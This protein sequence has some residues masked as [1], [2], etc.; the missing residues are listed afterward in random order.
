MGI[1]DIFKRRN[2][3]NI[4]VEKVRVDSVRRYNFLEGFKPKYNFG[5]QG[6]LYENQVARTCIDTIATHVAKLEP[7]HKRD[8]KIVQGDIHRIINRQPNPLMNRYD[9]I[10]KVV[11]NLY[12]KNNA[13]IYIHIENGMLKSL[14]PISYNNY[15]MVEDEKGN[16]YLSFYYLNGKHYILPMENII[17]LRRFYNENDYM[18]E[19][20]DV[21]NEAV[22]TEET[23][24]QG[25]KNAV[26]I[27]N[28]MRGLIKFKST[29]RPEDIKKRRDQFV[30]DALE[31]ENQ[32][33]IAAIDQSADFQELKMQ[34]IA[35]GKDQMD[36]IETS[37]YKYFR[38]SKKII[39]SDFTES[40]WNA[41]Y[42]AVVE[43]IAMQ[44][45][46][47]FTNK[48]FSERAINFGNYITF[49]TNI[50]DYANFET[51]IKLI[52]ETTQLGVWTKNEI[53]Q[54]FNQPPLANDEEGNKILQTL[55]VVDSE[56]ANQYQL[57]KSG[58]KKT[59]EE[60]DIENTE[61][62]QEETYSEGKK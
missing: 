18:G 38:I 7:K 56:I 30:D 1:L 61:S 21:L 15:E 29:L 16:I 45:S 42:R 40:E 59:K 17:T 35:L 23:A 33:G 37:I 3:R 55:N 50:L 36:Y 31:L 43:P 6:E 28:T 58:H 48:I 25:I 12:T 26:R 9:F 62:N 13:F 19:N 20:N 57:S 5:K 49:E 53:R 8:G 32:G 10:Y 52:K 60:E 54:I 47:E 14:Y 2:K 39:E 46:I 34:P 41:F 11:T 51:K 27:S 22:L 24:Q 44:L 4:P